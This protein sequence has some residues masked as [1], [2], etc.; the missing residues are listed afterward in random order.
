V[1]SGTGLAVNY[2]LF[3]GS[4]LP[5]YG[6][7][8]SFEGASLSLDG[9]FFSP[10]GVLDQ[11]LI[12]GATPYTD[13][14]ALRLDTTWSY[15]DPD[16]L[17]TYHAGDLI[18]GGLP[19]TRPVRLGGVQAQRNFAIRPDLVTLP[20]PSITGSAAVPSTV[21]IYV[22]NAKTYSQEVAAGPYA[23]TNLPVLTG[24]GAA[25]VVVRDTS[26]RETETTVSL[27]SSPRLLRPGLYDFSIE[28]GAPRLY[29]GIESNEYAAIPMASASLRAGIFED[30]TL[31]AHTEGGDGLINGGAGAVF[32]VGARGLAAAAVSGSV[33]DGEGGVQVYGSFE[34]VIGAAT[35]QLSSQRTFGAYEDVAS[36]S[37]TWP[38]A[39]NGASRETGE[40][41][42]GFFVA[43]RPPRSLDR[44]SLSMPLPW[45]SA[46]LSVAYVPIV[47]QDGSR[48]K[49]VSASY[50]QRL[51]WD[52]SFYSSAFVDLADQDSAGIYA[53]IS[54][55]L[56]GRISGAAGVSSDATGTHAGVH[57]VKPLE[58]EPGSFAWRVHDVEGDTPRREVSAAWRASVVRVGGTVRQ[59][60]TNVHGSAEL[61]GAVAVMDGGVFLA[62]RIDDAFAVVSAGAPDVEVF[63]ENRPI[64]RTDG[65]GKLLVPGL[66]AYQTNKI[67]IDP[68]GLPLDAEAKT[69]QEI[70]APGD[71]S[72]VA[73][74]FGVVTNLQAAVLILH[75][76]DGSP[77]QVGAKGRLEGGGEAFVVGY[78]GQAYVKGLSPS[79]TIV[80]ETADGE[81]RATFPFAVQR[82][83]QVTIGPVTCR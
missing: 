56:G 47:E 44:I 8:L 61:E 38:T 2:L 63:F 67:A 66:R 18:S 15:S 36:V 43:A 79:N 16:T 37:T 48:T 58:R 25:R 68:R 60:D 53:G 62:N 83:Q 41:P 72:G 6:E 71:R 54:M 55:S 74:D 40:D 45:A 28:A 32:K 75:G 35:L 52:A 19:W 73:V 9:R 22:G 59:F 26:G 57:V 51:P 1:T 21:D 14:T 20:L 34:T 69:T 7:G 78:D 70:V 76:A 12:L 77:L 42:I 17:V 33:H 39:F 81:C 49:L 29:Y 82:G 5:V 23:I 80:V 46:S 27:Y 10:Y 4:Q 65:S 13:A 3:A 64:G 11:S 30:L 31:E 24:N 50:S